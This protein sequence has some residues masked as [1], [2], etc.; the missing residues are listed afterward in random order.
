MC[1]RGR[2]RRP[3]EAQRKSIARYKYMIYEQGAN[4]E[5]LFDPGKDRGEMCNLAPAPAMAAMLDDQRK[6]LRAWCEE[7]GDADFLPRLTV[8]GTRAS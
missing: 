7:T 5:Q 2:N 6:R 4:R 1:S 8:S 3:R